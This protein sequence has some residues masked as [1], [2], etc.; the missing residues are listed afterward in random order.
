MPILFLTQS[1]SAAAAVPA[2]DVTALVLGFVGGMALFLYGVSLL[3]GALRDADDGR[4]RDLLA[5]ASVNRVAALLA[6]AAATVV[7]DSSSVAIILLIALIDARLMT[8]DRALPAVL[9]ANIGTTVSSQIFAWSLDEWSPLI[10]A[11][12]LIARAIAKTDAGKARATAVLGMGLILYGL[13]LLGVAAEPLAT[14][15]A[16]ID[17]LARL[18][19]PLSGAFAGA[20][21][22]VAIQSSSAMMGIAIALAVAGLVTLPAG[23]AIMLG[24]EIGTCADTLVAAAGRGRA[25]LKTGLFHL[26]FNIVCVAAGLLLIDVLI[27][28]A[29]AIGGDTGQQIANA[30][31][32]FNVVGALLILPFTGHAARLLDRLLPERAAAVPTGYVTSTA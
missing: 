23:V 26:G 13:H 16:V 20:I 5:R 21:A 1:T 3:A 29:Q 12:G 18:E 14:Q 11:A 28:A 10:V 32:L 15:P 8:F 31:M 27:G 7:L 25:A 24:A 30:H 4:M 2:L 9:G 19:N 17:A 6:G 22:T